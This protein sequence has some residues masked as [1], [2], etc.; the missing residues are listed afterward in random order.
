MACYCNA[1][2]IAPAGQTRVKCTWCIVDNAP[3]RMQLHE[4]C[5]SPCWRR[6]RLFRIGIQINPRQHLA[7][8]SSPAFSH[9]R[10][11]PPI[12]KSCSRE[13]SVNC[14]IHGE[15]VPVDLG[16]LLDA[17]SNQTT[18]FMSDMSLSRVT[19]SRFL[20]FF[21]WIRSCLTGGN[22]C[23]GLLFFHSESE[24]AWKRAA[25]VD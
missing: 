20:I 4:C 1:R 10:F 6:R 17:Y 15:A 23:F 18:D 9:R 16:S 14:R 8:V 13:I 19:W 24:N 11:S 2:W 5:C 25:W 7:R 12:G 3:T 21:R 22:R